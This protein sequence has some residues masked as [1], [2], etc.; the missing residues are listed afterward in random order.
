MTSLTRTAQGWRVRRH[1]RSRRASSPQSA[2]AAWKRAD[3][4]RRFVTGTRP[5]IPYVIAV[6]TLARRGALALPHHHP[7]AEVAHF[8]PPLVEPFRLHRDHTAVGLGRR[9][10]LAQHPG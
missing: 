4:S 5:S 6:G 2:T 7:P 8:L 3:A 10:P 9:L 1:G